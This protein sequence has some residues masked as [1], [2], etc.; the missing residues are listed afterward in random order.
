MDEMAA[1]FEGTALV[2]AGLA[3]GVALLCFLGAAAIGWVLARGGRWRAVAGLG[4]GLGLLA[5]ALG[6]L[7]LTTPWR[8]PLDPWPALFLGL[9]VPSLAGQALG[10]LA[11]LVRRR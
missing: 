10:V 7:A 9:A 6:A 5:A 2:L 4:A 11:G 1:D 3:G 8:S